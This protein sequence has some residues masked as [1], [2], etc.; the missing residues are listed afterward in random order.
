MPVESFEVSTFLPA[1]PWRVYEAWLDG[2]EHGLFTGGPATSEPAVG[3]VF[4][5]WDGYI[6]GRILALEPYSR[7][8]Q[9]W[10]TTEFPAESPD[11]CLEVLLD[12]EEG[13]TRL[14]LRH[15]EIPEGQGEEYKQGWL[16]FYF[17]PM[18]D[19]FAS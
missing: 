10:R 4:T 17:E 14:T 16:E 7:I 6:Q 2:T 3:G 15:S 12:T 8:L 1:P 13:G 11:S 9:S 18:R 19:Y 5:A